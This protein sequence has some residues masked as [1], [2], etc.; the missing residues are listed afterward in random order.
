MVFRIVVPE[1]YQE[2]KRGDISDLD[3]L[4]ALNRKIRRSDGWWRD[5]RLQ[6]RLPDV[7]V[8]VERA[9]IAWGRYVKGD[10]YAASP[11]LDKRERQRKE[12]P[13]QESEPSLFLEGVTDPSPIAPWSEV[14]KAS[15]IVEMV[16]YTPE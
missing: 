14:G 7:E 10:P 16:T 3:A 11:L 12:D 6:P 2:F 4:E 9:L 1:T 15:E 8:E 13:N 5:K